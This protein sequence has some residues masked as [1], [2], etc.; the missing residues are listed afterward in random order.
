MNNQSKLFSDGYRIV[1][2]IT[3]LNYNID[4]IYKENEEFLWKRLDKEISF[5]VKI[6][7]N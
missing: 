7:I 6:I 4:E 1:Y 2:R 3:E 5:K